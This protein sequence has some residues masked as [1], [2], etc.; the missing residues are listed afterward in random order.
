MARH[1]AIMV[2]T[3]MAAGL[4]GVGLAQHVLWDDEAVT[5]LFAS[6]LLETGAVVGWDG[7]NLTAYRGGIDLDEHLR[8]R[9]GNPL[10]H[11]AAAAG[12]AL[13]G[14]SAWAARLPFLLVGLATLWL[15]SRWSK[16]LVGPAV[17]DWLP[18]LLLALNVPYLLYITQCR[19]YA[20]AMGF[21]AAVLWAWSS[22][23]ETRRPRWCCAGGAL[24]VLGLSFSNPMNAA[25][26]VAA[27]VAAGIHPRFR[28]RR[29]VL[30]VGLIGIV[31]AT[32]IIRHALAA[33]TMAMWD[34]R[35]GGLS[36]FAR[37][38]LLM[39]WQIAGLSAFEFFPLLPVVLLFVPAFSK[40]LADFKATSRLAL[41]V[42][43]MMMT[44]L[45]VTAVLSPQNTEETWAADMRYLV[46]VLVMG[47]VVTAASIAIARAA[48]GRIAAVLL[49]ATIVLTNLGYG[50]RPTARCTLCERIHELTETH[51]SGSE[52]VIAAVAP[53]AGDTSVMFVPGYL[54]L[55]AMF[56]RPDLLYPGTLDPAKPISADLRQ[57][58]PSRVFMGASQPDVLVIG[59]ER[60]PVPESMEFLGATYRLSSVGST[61]WVDRTRP[62]LPWH[63]F[64]ANPDNDRLGIAVFRRDGR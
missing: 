16:R 1:L 9:E 48:F 37:F 34:A 39:R 56:Y 61:Y 19:Y 20:L 4:S 59:V 35:R 54:T 64:R 14:R 26:V 5:A 8:N 44:I 45:V 33:D 13:F 42:L 49:S 62:E 47:S 21:T 53:L 11:Y 55:V 41:A 28:S 15:V 52:A 17:P 43:A 57:S 7:R 23:D 6:N 3:A 32:V 27:C 12:M 50:A 25:A 38:V 60:L 36:L 22:L 29:H 10:Q 30:F 18:S 24:A 63:A 31:V 58:L 2:V 46:P 40:R 51:P